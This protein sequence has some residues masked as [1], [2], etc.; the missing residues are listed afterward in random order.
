[1]AKTLLTIPADLRIQIFKHL[2][3]SITISKGLGKTG[4][5]HTS[6]LTTCRQ[7]H[8]E[9]ILLLP[10]NVSFHFI[11]TEAMLDCLTTLTPELI[12]RIRHIRVKAFPFPLYAS[13]DA[14]YYT[15]HDFA[16]ILPIFPGLRLD[17]LVVEDCYHDEGIND[18][19]GD[20]GTYFT[21]QSLIESDG[22]NELHFVSPSTG[23]MSGSFHKSRVPQPA[24][25][26][27][28]LQNRDG[29]D[30]GA[31]VTMRVA[32]VPK[33]PGATENPDLCTAYNVVPRP[34]Y[35]SDSAP[36]IIDNG[37]NTTDR[38]VLVIASRGKNASYTQDGS[39]LAEE[40]RNLLRTMTWEEIKTS[41]L[42]LENEKDPCAHL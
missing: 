7:I 12:R 16:A 14:S 4:S 21:I 10:P 23:F 30:S 25:W 15:T 5:N 6:I 11:S 13:E 22:W 2:F 40:I 28:L 1:M 36:A 19:W 32:K 8:N 3:R 38:E 27:A 35:P 31:S 37:D 33:A 41:G 17:C 42:Y 39:N 24:R 26:N 34:E 9:A 29:Q 18:G 20:E